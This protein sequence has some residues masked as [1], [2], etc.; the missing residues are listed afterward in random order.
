MIKIEPGNRRVQ[1]MDADGTHRVGRVL[2]IGG[3]PLQHQGLFARSCIVR[4]DYDRGDVIVDASQ[5][6]F[7]PDA[8]VPGPVNQGAVR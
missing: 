8:P 4:L 7:Y 6:R 5:L 3:Y 2:F 1:W